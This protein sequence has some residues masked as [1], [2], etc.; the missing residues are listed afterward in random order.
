MISIV[1]YLAP[2]FG[3]MACLIV[4]FTR[5]IDTKCPIRAS[6]V[7]MWLTVWTLALHYDYPY[8][9]V[10]EMFDTAFRLLLLAI[11]CLYIAESILERRKR[12]KKI[13]PAL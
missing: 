12:I 13:N 7:C 2:F 11:N 6:K 9:L 4:V 10:N 3:L 8:D 1:G 5:K